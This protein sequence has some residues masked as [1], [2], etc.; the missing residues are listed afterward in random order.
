LYWNK[1]AKFD[2]PVFRAYFMEGL[3]QPNPELLL[4]LV[5]MKMPVAVPGS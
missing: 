4:D 2:P 5:K 1:K 3:P